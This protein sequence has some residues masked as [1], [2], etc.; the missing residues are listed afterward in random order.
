VVDRPVPL[1]GIRAVAEQE[2]IQKRHSIPASATQLGKAELLALV[3]TTTVMA[4]E[5]RVREH[6]VLQTLGFSPRRVFSLVLAECLLV[7]LAGGLLGVGL[8][9]GVLTWCGLSVTAEGVTIDFA[10]SMSLGIAGLVL[11]A[12]VGIMAG[13]APSWRAARADIVMSL[14]QV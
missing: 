6:A 7:G 10:P 9:E 3:A 4:V 5:D 12:A 1:F 13:L 14:R 11:A 2:A 8:A